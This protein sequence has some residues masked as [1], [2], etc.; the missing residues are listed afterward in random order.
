MVQMFFSIV[1]EEIAMKG[2]ALC[3]LCSLKSTVMGLWYQEEAIYNQDSA[4]SVPPFCT[5][6]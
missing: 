3:T 4:T 5:H 6:H 2:H 1:F